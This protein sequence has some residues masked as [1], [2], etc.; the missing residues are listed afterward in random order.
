[1]TWLSHELKILFRTRL[2]LI[3]SMLLL[4]LSS[5]AV[6]SGLLDVHK[7]QHSI[8]KL[9]Q[10]QNEDA[11][12]IAKKYADA[13]AGYQAY[14]TFYGTW[15]SPSPATFIALGFRDVA[16]HALRVRAL[17]LQAQIH[18]GENF[19]PEL[20]LPGRFDYAFV[21][22][23]L[24]PL[25]AIALLY[26]LVSGERESGRL[27]LLI[28][29]A[30]GNG[31]WIRRAGVRFVMLLLCCA[32]P[33]LIAGLWADM[34]FISLC[35]ALTMTAS[36]LAFWTGMC[37]IVASF[38][39]SSVA[40]AM[41]LMG[42]WVL[43]TLIVPALANIMISR[44]IPVGQGVDLMLSQRQAVHN[45]WEVPREETMRRFYQTYPE[46]DNQ[47]PLATG[48]QW[49]WYFAF[50]QL[51]D[52]HVA[53]SVSGYQN[54]LLEREQW[55]RRLGW[56]LPS[57]GVQSVMHGIAGTDLIAQLN[58]Q[59]RITQFHQQIREFYYDFLFLDKQFDLNDFESRPV[60]SD[61]EKRSSDKSP[62]GLVELIFAWAVMALGVFKVGYSPWE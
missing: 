15:D 46:L 43:I 51:G 26:D 33:L 4:G 21:L 8:A 31:I 28:S 6:V 37:L 56:V 35:L 30:N 25:F 57:V 27:R 34:S 48:F 47:Q 3:A 40:N 32:L 49:K 11:A 17:G 59:E 53:D 41:M 61:S 12:A 44:A 62:F 55:T 10:L 23:Y 39:W 22:V 42:S 13:G 52:Q 19:N 20:A 14:Y 60:F 1:M 50:H 45:A 24:L 16:P 54:A 36:Y 7:Q 58:Y 29:S 5:V 38:R 2:A 9:I 18:E